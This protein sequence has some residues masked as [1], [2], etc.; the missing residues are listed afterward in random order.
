MGNSA[1]YLTS[2]RQHILTYRIPIFSQ[3]ERYIDFHGKGAELGAGTCWL[4]S[5]LSKNP[6][7]DHVSIFEIDSQ[8]IKLARTHFCRLFGAVT[9]K[10][11]FFNDDFHSLPFADASLDFVVCDAALHHSDRIADLLQEIHRILKPNGVLLALREPVLPSLQPLR[12]WKRLTFGWRE[13]LL[14]DIEKTYTKQ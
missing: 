3:T 12:T 14:G 6:K 13:R 10:I 11:E 5:L 7:V 2:W 9:G 1:K 8:R 4:A